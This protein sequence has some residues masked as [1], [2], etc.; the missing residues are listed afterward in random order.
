M[1][2]KFLF[3]LGLLN[4]LSYGQCNDPVIT[5]FECGMPTQTIL[6]NGI[7]LV[8]NFIS[9]GINM[10]NNIGEFIDDGTNGWDNLLIDYGTEIDLTTNTILSFKLYS[11]SSIQV[12][13]K[14]E[15][16]TDVEVWSNFSSINT[17]E[18]FNF[19][20]SGAVGNGNSSLVLFF[21]AAQTSGTASDTYYIDDLQWTN[22][23]NTFPVISDF[24]SL[25]PSF[26]FQGNI[27]KVSNPFYFGINT[28]TNIGQYIDDGTNG[29]DNMQ[30]DFIT[31]VDISTT[32]YFKIKLY[33]PSSIQILAKLE[34]GS[35][36]EVWSDF[37]SVDT[38]EEFNF[39]FSSAINSGNTKLILFFNPGIDTG[40]ISE[41]YYIDDLNWSSTLSTQENDLLFSINVHPN[42]A[43]NSLFLNSNFNINS[44]ILSDIN[45]RTLIYENNI[46]KKSFEIDISSL[47][48]GIYFLKNFSGKQLQTI[49]I[50]KR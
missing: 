47:K 13:A 43:I 10:S 16:G 31:A 11:S 28:S 22:T 20:F 36:L 25:N 32:P 50:L 1:N 21:N 7:T 18:E 3:L 8:D 39:D 2:L 37:S 46:N 12:L 33:T 45:G 38:W 5:N 4:C 42:P 23:N 48:S 6:G 35:E 26:P 49:K 19:D 17:W 24:E 29:W 30:I 27:Q 44:F 14:L 41:I 9:S 40:S 15:G 34:G